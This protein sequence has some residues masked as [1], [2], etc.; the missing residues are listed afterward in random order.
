MQFMCQK[1]N[2]LALKS[3]FEFLR[4]INENPIDMQTIYHSYQ[5]FQGKHYITFQQLTFDQASQIV[6]GASCLQ[7]GGFHFL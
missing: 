5:S 7:L 6:E 4:I 1:Y 2:G 3:C